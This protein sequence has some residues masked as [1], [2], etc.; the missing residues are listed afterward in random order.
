MNVERSN[1]ISL[2]V[3]SNI[4]T[5]KSI[6][7][8]VRVIRYFLS[9]LHFCESLGNYNSIYDIMGGFHINYTSRLSRIWNPEMSSDS[10]IL[11]SKFRGV[12]DPKNNYKNYRETLARR[13]ELLKTGTPTIPIIAILK[14]D[15]ALIEE[16]NKDY[17]EGKINL[18]K[19]DLLTELCQKIHSFQSC[20][21]N[22]NIIKDY[23]LIFHLVNLY[24]LSEEKLNSRSEQIRPREV[25]EESDSSYMGNSSDISI[26]ME[27]DE[28]SESDLIDVSMSSG[29]R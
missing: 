6:K 5:Q 1:K 28:L 11:L 15:I 7:N 13:Y 12:T 21:Y 3:A 17:L 18:N 24:S 10:R 19:L 26:H 9:I 16:G 23:N 25:N 4:L 2:W 29:S 22:L 14:R 27:S 20:K 8:Q